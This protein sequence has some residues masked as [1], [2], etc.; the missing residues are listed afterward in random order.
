VNALWIIKIGKFVAIR[1]CVCYLML[2]GGLLVSAD[3]DVVV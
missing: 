2:R 3:A 1:R